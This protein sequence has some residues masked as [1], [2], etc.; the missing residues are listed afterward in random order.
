MV[1]TKLYACCCLLLFL[2]SPILKVTSQESE[3]DQSPKPFIEAQP[4]SSPRVAAPARN[5]FSALISWVL[6]LVLVIAVIY[7]LAF[8]V[9]KGLIRTQQP[10]GP[11]GSF[12]IIGHLTLSPKLMLY[13]VEVADRIL[14]M[15]IT[16]NSATTLSEITEPEVVNKLRN[17]A[18]I[19]EPRTP[20]FVEYFKQAADRLKR[21]E[22]A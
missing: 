22:R 16:D 18:S 21:I 1:L 9:R 7:I 10:L 8:F 15:A 20:N 14:V 17:E 6:A 12:R 13:L 4:E 5:P 19:Y 11:Q 2:F 3:D